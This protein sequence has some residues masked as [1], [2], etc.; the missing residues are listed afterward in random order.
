MDFLKQ[1]PRKKIDL[2]TIEAHYELFDYKDL[3]QFIQNARDMGLLKPV[4]NS[5]SN[6]K[7]PALHKKYHIQT[8]IE[9]EENL[10]AELLYHLHPTLKNDYYLNRLQQYSEDRASILKLSEFFQKHASCLNQPTAINERSFQIWQK[11]KFLA[12]EGSRLLKNVGLSLSDLN[13]YETAEPL[14][15]YSASKQTPQNILII[16]NKDTFYSMRKFLIEGHS[17]LL[18]FP[19]CT[20]IYGGGK[21]GI[22]GF[23]HFEA[24]VEPYLLHEENR[25]YYFGDLDYEGIL[26]FESLCA[27]FNCEPFVSAYEA[28]LKKSVNLQLPQTKEKQNRNISNRFFSYFDDVSQMMAIL[29]SECY[30]PQEILTMEDF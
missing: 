26:I 6:G 10:R 11:E 12:E 5:G 22:K 21:K 27:H 17:H 1:Y 24:S 25:F 19:I 2:S 3:C 16:E 14:A 28:M 20:L 13:L 9:N 23:Q 15:Y 18:G 29:E 7:K 8:I 30:I 4:Q